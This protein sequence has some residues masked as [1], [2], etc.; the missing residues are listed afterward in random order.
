MSNFLKNFLITSINQLDNIGDKRHLLYKKLGINNY[1][2]LLLWLP[3]KVIYK[4]INPAISVCVNGLPVVIDV[5]VDDVDIPHNAR[6]ACKI[7]CRAANDD[8]FLIQIVYFQYKAKQISQEYKIGQHLV[9]DGS[10]TRAYHEVQIIHPVKVVLPEHRFKIWNVEPVYHCTAGLSSKMIAISIRSVLSKLPKIPEWLPNEKLLQE[11]WFDFKKSLELM[12]FPPVNND[13]N[14]FHKARERIA[15][16]EMLHHQISLNQLRSR[17]KTKKPFVFE[18][19]LKNTMISSL[20]FQLTQCQAQAISEIENDMLSTL[21]SIRLLQGDVGAG[22]TIVALAILLNVV[23]SGCQGAL[24]VPT[25]L[26][27]TQHYNSFEN[28]CKTC[29]V[30]I[31]LLTGNMSATQ[32]RKALSDIQTG[33]AQIIIGTHALIQ[34]S[35][36]YCN[37]RYVIIDEQ[38][39]FGVLQRHALMNKANDADLLMMTATPIPRTLEMA[40]YGDI[41]VSYLKTKPANRK[42]IITSVISHKKIDDLIASI[43]A[44]VGNNEKVY[45]ICPLIDESESLNLVHAN[46]RFESLDKV[47]P[48]LVGIMHGKMKQ[49]EKDDVMRSFICGDIRVIVST[50]VIEVGIDVKDASIMVIEHA[51]RFGLAQL[52]Q[53]RGRVGRGDLQSYCI[54]IYGPAYGQIS[55]ERLKIMKQTNDGFII[56]EKDLNLRQPGDVVGLKQSGALNFKVFNF[57]VDADMMHEAILLS[58]KINFQDDIRSIFFFMES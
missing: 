55:Q 36:T 29:N 33:A 1:R 31:V 16:D 26:L 15:F 22:K 47:L 4:A 53:L 8:D 38:H 30:K 48:S 46:Q 20:S 19:N 54:L 10:I 49:S 40:I 42:D 27:A 21:Q 25:E 56:A 58:R 41:N 52:H 34:S 45:W 24:M 2:D 12:H 13:Q 7:L 35:V 28:I 57:D 9:I 37:L 18:K 14:L 3:Y 5:I 51:E 6:G 32:K 44:R 17:A 43:V 11:N 50:T 39:R 23:E